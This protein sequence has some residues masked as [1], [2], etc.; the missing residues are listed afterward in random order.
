[1]LAAGLN[2]TAPALFVL[3]VGALVLGVRPRLAS[4]VAYGIVAWSFLVNLVGSVIKGQDWIRD[5][6]LFAH[7]KL[8][9]SVN[10]DWGSVAIMVLLGVG[11]AV[12]GALAFARRDIEYA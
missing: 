2:A 6:S 5:S 11:A 1:L 4:A 12:V 10:P 7:I 3:G 8:A 9:P